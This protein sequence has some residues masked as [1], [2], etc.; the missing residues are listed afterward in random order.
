MLIEKK[1]I[2][3]ILTIIFILSLIVVK[4]GNFSGY[5]ILNKCYEDCDKGLNT[6]KTFVETSFVLC[7]NSADINYKSCRENSYRDCTGIPFKEC[8]KTK[9]QSCFEDWKF[10]LKQCES[11]AELSLGSCSDNL[12]ECTEKCK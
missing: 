2:I 10:A 9:L 5:A 7:R 8:L 4:T 6:C 11:N 12:L 3:F 1:N